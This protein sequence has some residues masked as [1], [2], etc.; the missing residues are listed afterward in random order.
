[1]AVFAHSPFVSCGGEKGLP[2]FLRWRD[3]DSWAVLFPC[4]R[5]DDEFRALARFFLYLER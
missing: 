1:M 5:A 4:E 3:G 2:F